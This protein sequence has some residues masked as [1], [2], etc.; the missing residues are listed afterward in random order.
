MPALTRGQKLLAVV[1][2][3]IIALF[4]TGVAT[5][6]GSG[7]QSD[8]SEHGLVRLLGGWF[9]DPEQVS[10]EELSSPCLAGG[11]LTIED[12][13]VLTV[14]P[15]EKDLREIRLRPEQAVRLQTRA[16]HD[17]TNLDKD[18]SEDDDIKVAVDGKG[19]DITLTCDECTVM[20]GD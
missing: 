20:V 4:V 18:L 19:V 7:E 8:P 17:D 11:K 15:S 12:S 6:D 3:L 10:P 14:A 9:A 2:V 16:P 1:A 13:C 5:Q